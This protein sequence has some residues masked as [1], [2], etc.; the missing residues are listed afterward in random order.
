MPAGKA[1]KRRPAWV[2]L[3]CVG[4][5]IVGMP[6]RIFKEGARWRVCGCDRGARLAAIA[7]VPVGK[8]VNRI[9]TGDVDA[10]WF[11]R[12]SNPHPPDRCGRSAILSYGTASQPIRCTR[13][14][15]HTHGL[16]RRDGHPATPAPSAQPVC[17]VARHRDRPRVHG[18]HAD[19]LDSP[20]ALCRSNRVRTGDLPLRRRTLYPLSYGTLVA[21]PLGRTMRPRVGHPSDW[22]DSNPRPP[23]PRPGA[24]PTAPQSVGRFS[25][26]AGTARP[27]GS[28]VTEER[29][30]PECPQPDSNRRRPP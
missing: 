21:F 20:R 1:I 2:T 25:R 7:P 29:V 28:R 11:R 10:Q 6:C 9:G 17:V 13:W 26:P 18:A 27:C 19:C 12:A 30:R 22:R 3:T 5:K 4:L 14:G 15:V 8:M 24:L 23:G 16:G